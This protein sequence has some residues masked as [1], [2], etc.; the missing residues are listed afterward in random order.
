[1]TITNP[2]SIFGCYLH[3]SL[4]C[5]AWTIFLSERLSFFLLREGFICTGFIT[6]LQD[7]RSLLC[8]D[9]VVLLTKIGFMWKYWAVFWEIL[10][11][12]QNP[13][14]KSF[15]TYS[16]GKRIFWYERPMPKSG[17]PL[18]CGCWPFLSPSSDQG[19]GQER[20]CMNRGGRLYHD[21]P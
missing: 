12:F 1:M 10:S 16:A 5:H 21:M 9:L 18:M 17:C 3:A 4:S 2:G 7:V 15:E 19:L 6:L 14:D 11:S 8:T 13:S 20:I